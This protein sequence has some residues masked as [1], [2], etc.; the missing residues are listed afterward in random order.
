METSSKRSKPTSRSSQTTSLSSSSP[1]PRKL[2][3]FLYL[4]LFHIFFLNVPLGT[5][6]VQFASSTYRTGCFR[7]CR[8]SFCWR[9]G[10]RGTRIRPTLQM[11]TTCTKTMTSWPNLKEGPK[12][13]CILTQSALSSTL[14]RGTRNRSRLSRTSSSGNLK[15]FPPTQKRQI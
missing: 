13:P 4:S 1:R 7:E 8:R 3:H 11:S 10:T 6:S 14:T 12:S 5:P 9:T 15:Q 2:D